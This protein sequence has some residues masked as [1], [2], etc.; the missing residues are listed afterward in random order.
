MLKFSVIISE[1][2][3][4]KRKKIRCSVAVFVCW[5]VVVSCGVISKIAYNLSRGNDS[6]AINPPVYREL[7]K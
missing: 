4:K 7:S 3:P 5:A 2:M 1:S 6:S